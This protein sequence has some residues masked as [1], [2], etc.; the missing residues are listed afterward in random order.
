M[1][2]AVLWLR[3][4]GAVLAGIVVTAVEFLA[5]MWQPPRSQ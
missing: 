4:I 5:L 1:S 3:R 2:G